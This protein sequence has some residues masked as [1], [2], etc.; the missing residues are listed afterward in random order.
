MPYIHCNSQVIFSMTAELVKFGFVMGVVM[1]GFAMSFHALFHTSETFGETFLNLFKAMLGEV[2]FFDEFASDP[3]DRVATILLVVYLVIITIMLLNLLVAILSTSHA[4]V[5]E[6]AERE[7]NIA[8]ARMIQHYRLVVEKNYLP[9]PFNLI[10]L[11]VSLPFRIDKRIFNNGEYAGA[12][13]VVGEVVFWLVLGPLAVAGGTALWITSACSATFVWRKH[14]SAH[15]TV[16]SESVG[17]FDLATR[18]MHVALEHFIIGI[19]CVM[20]APLCLIGLWLKAPSAFKYIVQKGR[21]VLGHAIR[22]PTVH[23]TAPQVSTLDRR[24]TAK[25]PSTVAD[26]LK[27][28]DGQP[29]VDDLRKYLMNPMINK[30]VREDDRNRGATVE[31]V[32]LF[33]C[34]MSGRLTQLEVEQLEVKKSVQAIFSVAKEMQN[35]LDEMVGDRSHSLSDNDNARDTHSTV[36]EAR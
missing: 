4:M 13:R 2:G 26:M 23:G 33:H 12:K 9:A 19:W 20:G 7:S 29:E 14:G 8:K 27:H 16:L 6:H 34:E 18:I 15:G 35:R 5:H 21:R 36:R 17:V 30:K 31:H 24:R 22:P 1:V 32:K 28:S 3:D 25:G 10:Q 11:A